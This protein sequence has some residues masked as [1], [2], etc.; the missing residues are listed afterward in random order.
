MDGVDH[1]QFCIALFLDLFDKIE[2]GSEVGGLRG[3]II[4]RSIGGGAAFQ[5]SDALG[6]C[7]ISAKNLPIQVYRL[8]VLSLG[9]Y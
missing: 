3:A 1:G 5:R 9:V 8:L 7:Q 6:A 2:R 4:Q